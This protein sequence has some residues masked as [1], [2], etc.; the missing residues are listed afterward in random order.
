MTKTLVSCSTSEHQHVSTTV[1]K[2]CFTQGTSLVVDC[3][4][5]NNMINVLTNISRS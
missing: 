1:P 2:Y 3:Q 5:E 4:T